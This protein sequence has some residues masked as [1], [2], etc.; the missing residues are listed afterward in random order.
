MTS[1]GGTISLKK[2]NSSMIVS[3]GK[4]R[5]DGFLRGVLSVAKQASELQGPLL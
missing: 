1:R 2:T 4:S 3:D 5:S